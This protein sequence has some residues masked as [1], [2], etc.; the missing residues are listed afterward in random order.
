M[1]MPSIPRKLLLG[2]SLMVLVVVGGCKE[3]QEPAPP[4]KPA[5]VR[6]KIEAPQP[7]AVEPAKPGAPEVSVPAVAEA[8]PQVEVPEQ[9]PLEVAKA[10]PSAEKP[11]APEAAPEAAPKAAPETAPETAPEAAPEVAAGVEEGAA[12]PEAEE[13]LGYTY[14]PQGKIDPFR[15]VFVTQPRKALEVSKRAR[16]RKMPL[17]PLQ[18]L[19]VSQLKVVGIIVS[20]TGN[21]ALV[22]DPAGKGYV[23]TVGTYVGSNFG[24]VTKIL[25]DRV[26]VEEEVED[27]FTG[28]MKLQP[29]ELRLQKK[30]GEV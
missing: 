19:G 18:K 15:S 27:F 9:P 7:P 21:K 1:T 30:F 17:T 28:K 14:D 22:E 20:P 29:V 25:K 16:E 2:I 10:E 23:I 24:R 3:R 5:V 12:K 6:K 11:A 8:P 26:I 4:Q 13:T